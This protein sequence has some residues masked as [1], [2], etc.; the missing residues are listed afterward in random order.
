MVTDSDV[1]AVAD[2][3]A[4]A[5]SSGRMIEPPS[6]RLPGFDVAA[7]YAVAAELV[8][9]NVEAQRLP[10]GWKGAMT[11]RGTWDRLRI[12]EPAWGVLWEDRVTHAES[13]S[14]GGLV[15]P[16][17]EG[18]IAFGLRDGRLAVEA[19]EWVALAFEVVQC[20]YPGWRMTGADGIADFCLHEALVLGERVPAGDVD[21]HALAEVTA[22]MTCDGTQAATGGGER[23][24][25]D[26]LA[27]VDWMGSTDAVGAVP[28]GRVVTTGALAGALPLERG[29][30]WR[31]TVDGVALPPVDVRL[32]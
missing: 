19:I 15:Q 7:G 31:L 4:E 11:D 27:V 32:E 25:G 29:Q 23:V 8:R 13:L 10:W 24:F 30:R 18:E 17:I 5:R 1:A 20:H 28:A 6:T 21:L 3:L 12:T 14:V 9:R 26:P 2:E 22:V 16:R